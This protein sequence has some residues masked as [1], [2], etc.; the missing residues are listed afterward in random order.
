MRVSFKR[1]LSLAGATA[2]F[3][4]LLLNIHI[5]HTSYLPIS[6]NLQGDYGDSNSSQPASHQL[7]LDI[8]NLRNLSEQYTYGLKNL[9]KLEDRP[10]YMRKGKVR[11]VSCVVDPSTGWRDASLFPEEAEGD[12]MLNQLLYVPPAKLLPNQESPDTPLKKILLWNGA[13]AWGNTKPGRGLFM[14]LK[15][16]VSTCAIS[17]KRNDIKNADLVIFKDRFVPPRYDRP[18][19]QLWMMYM[20]ECPMHTQFFKQKDVFNWTATYRS[21]STLV[22]PYSRW[23][24][25]DENIKVLPVK[26]NFAEKKKKKV[27]WFVSNC[28]AKNNRLEYAQALS[29]FIQVD[30][31]GKC[32][33]LK[34]PR[35]SQECLDL[36]DSDYKFYLA[37]ENSNCKDYITEKFFVNG[38]GHDVIPIVMGARLEDYE[39]SAPKKSF[40]HV[41]NFNSPS[42]LAKYLKKLDEND[43]LYNEYFQWK[44]T[45]EMIDTKFFCR[46]CSLLHDNKDRGLSGHYSDINEWW[47]GKG[48]CIK[49]SWRAYHKALAHERAK[50][51]NKPTVT[52]KEKNMESSSEP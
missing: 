52:K 28:N 24:Y 29:K 44:D 14:K 39:R 38:L 30:I 45:G 4:V 42:Q 15:C 19:N 5:R 49:G 34:C 12:R 16:P 33:T 6:D 43:D 9:P 8:I 22:A 36:L 51:R 27:A 41:D 20:L 35:N 13:S 26:K 23:E 40:I 7:P 25:Y 32:G 18:A 21:D 2:G 50:E 31:F 46:M 1:F 47:R 48:T 11:P 3:F 17:T 37:F 10:W